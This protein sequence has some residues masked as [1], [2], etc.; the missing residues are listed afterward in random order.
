MRLALTL[1]L[2]GLTATALPLR[3]E[4]LFA[5]SQIENSPILP[6][7]E[8]DDAV[9]FRTQ[10]DL[11][12]AHPMKDA[13]VDQ[14]ARLS[15][16]LERNGTILIY[17]TIPSKSQGMPDA[18]PEQVAGM[19]YDPSIS[20]AAY[21][22]I[23]TRL[24]AKGILAPDLMTAL[25][26]GGTPERP[27]QAT[28]FH[29]TSSGAL[30]AARAIGAAIRAHPTYADL[31]PGTYVSTPLEPVDAFSTMRRILQGNCI[32][33]L[34]K[35][36]TLA[37]ET[38]RQDNPNEPLDLGLAPTP[39]TDTLDIFADGTEPLQVVLVGT[40]FSDNDVD[41][42]A[43][44]LSEYSGLE[45]VNHAISGGNQFGAI[46]SYLTSTDYPADRPRFLIWEN[47]VYNNLG[48]YGFAP[49]EEL[50][51]A[52]NNDCEHPLP[53][54]RQGE[55]LIADLTGLTLHPGDAIRADFGTEGPRSVRFSLTGTNGVTRSA[56]IKRED[57]LRPTGR[58]FLGL[59]PYLRADLQQVRAEFDRPLTADSQL[60]LCL[61]PKE[62][63]A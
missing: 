9:F 14:L 38:V 15:Q 59:T 52:A 16:A 25:Q 6:T 49:L 5:C 12:M 2:M 58:F 28:D 42:F 48:R 21:H 24:N 50:I 46:T 4:S 18:L 34:P 32:G 1:A 27:F 62:D 51:A 23:I 26:Q 7:V 39:D 30:L 10:S 44:F 35:V 63:P 17:A 54:H 60:S 8:S 40:S 3:A 11:R 41:N 36:E 13:V 43:G 22:D 37:W 57:R 55:S 33:A 31:T 20:Q 45:V 19:G 56:L 61:S 53:L 29:W 47:P